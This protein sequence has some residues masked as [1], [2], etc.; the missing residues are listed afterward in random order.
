MI[1]DRDATPDHDAYSPSADDS[2]IS[3]DVEHAA[4]APKFGAAA[5]R[6]VVVEGAEPVAVT[7]ETDDDE[8]FIKQFDLSF[9]Q[10]MLLIAAASF[11]QLIASC[12]FCKQK[13]GCDARNGFGVA[14]G[15]VSLVLTLGFVV[16]HN[17]KGPEV[18]TPRAV[19]S[20]SLFLFVWWFA[21]VVTNTFVGECSVVNNCWLS[22]WIAFLVSALLA[23]RNIGLLRKS[24]NRLGRLIPKGDVESSSRPHVLV[25]GLL[26]SLFVCLSAIGPCS[27]S[28]CNGSEIYALVVSGVSFLFYIVLLT[29]CLS[30]SIAHALVMTLFVLWMVS[31]IVLTS[32]GPWLIAGNGW[33]ATWFSLCVSAVVLVHHRG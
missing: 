22:T 6:P 19:Q 29:E 14:V 25:F 3:M 12:A 5:P 15:L 4:P 7:A 11:L 21:S 23:I 27:D 2:T 16:Y 31:T 20:I 18:E 1:P 13:G 32:A 33:A 10:T 30:Q 26:G 28:G 9:P 17:Q 8:V 24:A